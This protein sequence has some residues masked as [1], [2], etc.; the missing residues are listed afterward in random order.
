MNIHLHL[1]EIC[2]SNSCSSDFVHEISR[3]CHNVSEHIVTKNY[4]LISINKKVN[5]KLYFILN[6]KMHGYKSKKNK[7]NGQGCSMKWLL[8]KKGNE[9]SHVVGTGQSPNKNPM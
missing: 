1:T 3:F 8:K 7:K 5:K 6:V 9:T 4:M 2:A